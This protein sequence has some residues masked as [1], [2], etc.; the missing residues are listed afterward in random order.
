MTVE[1]PEAKAPAAEGVVHDHA[2]LAGSDLKEA[3]L[4]AARLRFASLAA[5]RLEGAD[6]S[7]A[8]I[9]HAQF[10]DAN[11]AGADLGEARLDH[12]NFACADLRGANLVDADARY[13]TFSGAR[14]VGADLSFA[15]CAHAR[16]DG[17]DLSGA[18]L[19]NAG[20]TN[21]LFAGA[22]LTDANL[23]GA[24]LRY[25]RGLT[26]SQIGSCFIDETTR[27]PFKLSTGIGPSA[28]TPYRGPSPLGLT[29]M[30]VA[31]A[32]GFAPVAGIP[33]AAGR[34]MSTQAERVWAAARAR[35]RYALGGVAGVLLAFAL[36]WNALQLETLRPSAAAEK[37]NETAGAT[38]AVRPVVPAALLSPGDVMEPVESPTPDPVPASR[39]AT[40]AGNAEIAPQPIPAVPPA[41]SDLVL[42]RPETAKPSGVE[43]IARR[44]E[45]G[46]TDVV[47][48]PE[49]FIPMRAVLLDKASLTAGKMTAVKL[50]LTFVS[51][52][53]PE[54]SVTQAEPPMPAT[55]RLTEIREETPPL[56]VVVSLKEQRLDLYQGLS[57]LMSSE[58]SS[59]KPG[60]ETPSGVFSILAKAKTHAATPYSGTPMPWMQRLTRS[61]LALHG[62]E[63]AGRPAS[64]GSVRLPMQFAQ[65]LYASTDVG[66]NVVIAEERPTPKPIEHRALF[67]PGERSGKDESGDA[68]LVVMAEGAGNEEA[69]LRILIARR[70]TRDEMI[71]AQRLLA[72]MGY[73]EEW[74]FLGQMEG[75]TR[76]GIK[77]FERDY[78]MPV[79][80]KFTG[81]FL[82][83]LYNIAGKKRPPAAQLFVRQDYRRLYD[84]PV[85]LRSGDAPLGTQIFT[86]EA[87]D[88]KTG[89]ARWMAVSLEG[90]DP[91]SV[92]DRIE[93][94]ASVR[95][96]ICSRLT[97]AS[98][99]I[100]AD[101]AE[102]SPILAAGDDFVVRSGKHDGAGETA[103]VD[104]PAAL[105][106]AP[107]L[108]RSAPARPK[109]KR[110]A[111]GSAGISRVSAPLH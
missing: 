49:T 66:A 111:T 21:A 48:E 13:A 46:E 85:V 30:R 103:T 100:V 4:H 64:R 24:D 99:L 47:V 57:L 89:K 20:L 86:V 8:D 105:D 56:T 22:D 78:E 106:Q 110:A 83:K 35:P 15:D 23:S 87:L 45:P 79:T 41:R 94:P 43:E 65:K 102:D 81:E 44:E 107:K 104:E 42:D 12:A 75:E 11:L 101:M 33:A 28:K 80:G 54:A 98:T 91:G 92:L 7:Q 96:D 29:R 67:Q 51:L 39:P 109:R 77:A 34:V 37:L 38:E 70:T 53:G 2:N 97:P 73:I 60:R 16:F 108:K 10:N 84:L 6:L 72:K 82:D 61:G 63:V 71:D 9:Q 5:A 14:L 62:G 31:F 3:D 40:L 76:S 55:I 26:A 95:K 1:Q 74:E 59:G 32:R 17:A 68:P 19:V 58:I 36:I 69:P 27:L 52:G 93:I 88:K 18:I 90:G 50:A 25:A